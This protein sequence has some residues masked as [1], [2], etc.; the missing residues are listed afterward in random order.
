[1]TEIKDIIAKIGNSVKSNWRSAYNDA[2]ELSKFGRNALPDIIETLND[3]NSSFEHKKL[4]IFSIGEI[5]DTFALPHL[6]RI[7]FANTDDK[8]LKEKYK[9]LL[10]LHSDDELLGLA[11]EVNDAFRKLNLNFNDAVN[12]VEQCASEGLECIR[13]GKYDEALKHFNQYI[14]ITPFNSDAIFGRGVARHGIGE[15]LGACE[16]WSESASLGNKSAIEFIDKFCKKK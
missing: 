7:L 14:Y 1:M 6:A 5:G 11:M 12:T 13:S 4:L 9:A 2:I 15:Q 3:S 8:L 16:D 10:G